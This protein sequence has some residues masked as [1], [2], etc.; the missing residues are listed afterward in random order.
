MTPSAVLHYLIPS[1]PVNITNGQPAGARHRS[2]PGLLQLVDDSENDVANR[3]LRLATHVSMLWVLTRSKHLDW[4]VEVTS[5][6]EIAEALRRRSLI[7]T[8]QPAIWSE[9]YEAWLVDEQSR[10]GIVELFRVPLGEVTPL[11]GRATSLNY[12]RGLSIKVDDREWFLATH[13]I[14]TPVLAASPTLGQDIAN[15][16]SER[17][18]E[19][20]DGIMEAWLSEVPWLFGS[21]FGLWDAQ[22]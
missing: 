16:V 9:S 15:K 3:K 17:N 13:L 6:P 4:L 19:A 2:V 1:M 20:I 21:P 5:R 7:K 8:K 11:G 14:K 22:R 12:I 18:N 10:K